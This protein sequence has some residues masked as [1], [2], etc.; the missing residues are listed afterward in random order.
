M[1]HIY[2][3]GIIRFQRALR[4]LVSDEMEKLNFELPNAYNPFVSESEEPYHALKYAFGMKALYERAAL[5]PHYDHRGRPRFPYLGEIQITLRDLQ[6]V[7]TNKERRHIRSRRGQGQIEPD[8]YIAPELEA[9]AMAYFPEGEVVH[10]EVLKC[11]NFSGKYKR[12]YQE[13][14]GLSK[15][16][17]NSFKS[18]LDKTKERTP[19]RMVVEDHLLLWLCSYHA[20]RLMQKAFELT[21]ARN[22][23][24]QFLG[25]QHELTDEIPNEKAVA[26]DKDAVD[27]RLKLAKKIYEQKLT[28]KK[29][30][31]HKLTTNS[32]T[33]YAVS[34]K[35]VRSA[36]KE[37]GLNKEEVQQFINKEDKIRTPPS[38]SRIPRSP[39]QRD[40]NTPKSS[41]YSRQ[42]EGRNRS[43]SPEKPQQRRKEQLLL[44]KFSTLLAA[45]FNFSNDTET[46]L[47]DLIPYHVPYH[48][49]DCLFEAIA[50]AVPGRQAAHI[51]VM[52]IHQ[53][54]HSEFLCERIAAMAGQEDNALRTPAGDRTYE[55]VAEYQELMSQDQTWGTQ[56]EIV[57]L[58][59]ALQR[60]IVV[61]TP[62]NAYDEV[63]GLEYYPQAEPI[64]LNYVNNNHY[65]PLALPPQGNALVIIAQIQAR[66][67]AR[68]APSVATPLLNSSPKS[69][70]VNKPSPFTDSDDLAE[71]MERLFRI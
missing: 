42:S 26:K 54:R 63:I 37:L 71:V 59:Q 64:F 1:Q 57:A 45:A 30:F 48:I 25:K 36:L 6:T 33:L 66:Q 17:F 49:G 51:R 5:R 16:L 46:E 35:D 27:F 38:A 50:A 21:H 13:K 2:T 69:K 70:P 12:Q 44:D 15:A 9:T 32:T 58:M 10:S 41:P 52:A 28:D 40:D 68:L 55:T 18:D 22:G 60:P 23:I 19:E 62:G 24:L 20:R 31:D 29:I 14:F 53:I 39:L 65:E 67:R 61:I 7:L 8:R 4:F 11:P 34:E 56:L 43:S 47:F 3:N